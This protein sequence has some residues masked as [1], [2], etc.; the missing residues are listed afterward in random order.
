[1]LHS[2]GIEVSIDE[3]IRIEDIIGRLTLAPSL[4]MLFRQS[5][6]HDLKHKI[7]TIVMIQLKC[8]R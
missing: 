2:F 8:G 6:D 4:P 7:P 3:A 1:M 5:T